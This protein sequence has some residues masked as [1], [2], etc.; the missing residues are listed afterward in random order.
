[1]NPFTWIGQCLFGL[2][3]NSDV[4]RLAMAVQ[5][6]QSN[7]ERNL[8]Q[9]RAFKNNAT[10][11]MRISK[12]RMDNMMETITVVHNRLQ[13]ATKALA[14]RMMANAQLLVYAVESIQRLL[15]KLH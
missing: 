3:S 13:V 15:N 4:R 9:F 14:Q 1:M 11:F 12:A 5:H 6:L 10:S 7:Q 2:A 8:D